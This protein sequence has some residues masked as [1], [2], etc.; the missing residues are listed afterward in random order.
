MKYISNSENETLC[1]ARDLGKTLNAGDIVALSGEL[2]AGKTV[3]VRGIC[4]ALGL[5][6]VHSP[7]FTLVNEYDGQIPVY[8]FDAYRLE[9]ND[10]DSLG[11]DE[12]IYSHGISLIEWSERISL[13]ECITVKIKGSGNQPREISIDILPQ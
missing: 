10:W 8:H 5:H 3:F 6:D 7:T 1:I 11:F 2:G 12:Y 4:E 9:S 13:P